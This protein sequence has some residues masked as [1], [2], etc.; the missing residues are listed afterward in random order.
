MNLHNTTRKFD[1]YTINVEGAQRNNKNIMQRKNVQNVS[2]KV[3]K[4]KESETETKTVRRGPQNAA[5]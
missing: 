5:Q 2:A 1:E 3:T 4:R